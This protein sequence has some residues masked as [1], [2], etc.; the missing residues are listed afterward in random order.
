[1]LLS[2]RAFVLVAGV[3]ACA[4]ISVWAYHAYDPYPFKPMLSCLAGFFVGCLTYEAY[5]AWGAQLRVSG[6]GMFSLLAFIAFLSLKTPHIAADVAIYPL[7][8]LL[9]FCV[10]ATPQSMIARGLNLRPL[11]FLGLISYS[12]YMAHPLVI[13]VMNQAVRFGL[14]P[15]ERAVADGMV[16]T[17]SAVQS[18]LIYPLTLAVILLIS[19]LT[20]YLIEAPC[21]RYS[22]KL[23]GR[24]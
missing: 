23:I 17:L 12:L 7:S 16:P 24:D 14:K 15:P 9:I 21:R 13:W 6:A 2:R 4:A 8:A 3:L 10:A 1:M 5:R 11:R 22:R 19:A 20:Y 18:L